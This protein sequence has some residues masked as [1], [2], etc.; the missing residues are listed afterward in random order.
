M[1]GR[2]RARSS[3]AASKSR[4]ETWRPGAGVVRR[5]PVVNAARE[6]V[7]VVSV[8]DL[9]VVAQ[10]LT[11]AILLV[12]RG[13]AAGRRDVDGRALARRG[14]RVAAV[15][16]TG[17]RFG[18]DGMA[19]IFARVLPGGT[20]VVRVVSVLDGLPAMAHALN[21]HDPTIVFGYP[22]ARRRSAVAIDP[23]PPVRDPRA[24]KYR[25]AWTA[26]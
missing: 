1:R 13:L 25:E 7:R 21:A 16:A 20:R 12:A 26:R 19:R 9:A 10:D 2:S 3:N 23:A 18:S 24:G 4:A 15:V 11:D 22:T 17:R 14:L 5:V 6:L 8:S